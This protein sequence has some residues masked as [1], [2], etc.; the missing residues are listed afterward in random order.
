MSAGINITKWAPSG[1]RGAAVLVCACVFCCVLECVWAS[2]SILWML[3]S[4]K[5]R[6]SAWSVC[7]SVCVCLFVLSYFYPRE[8]AMQ[9]QSNSSPP[10]RCF[11]VF[12]K[13]NFWFQIT[14]GFTSRLTWAMLSGT[15]Q[16][17]TSSFCVK[18]WRMNSSLSGRSRVCRA[19]LCCLVW[20]SC[21]LRLQTF[22]EICWDETAVLAISVTNVVLKQNISKQSTNIQEDD[23]VT[24]ACPQSIIKIRNFSKLIFKIRPESGGFHRR[25]I[26]HL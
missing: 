16:S 15:S 1:R 19:E 3:H 18:Q 17:H 5:I 24:A 10:F 7:V 4:I 8:D 2:R 14:I 25:G 22:A 9:N 20:N 23:K 11:G 21:L 13:L 6:P 12:F 26:C